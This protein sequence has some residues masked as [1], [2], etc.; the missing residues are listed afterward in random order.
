MTQTLSLFKKILQLWENQ[1]GRL[2]PANRSNF[3]SHKL[4]KEIAKYPYS[5]IERAM[6][7][8]GNKHL[9]DILAFLELDAEKRERNRIRYKKVY[10]IP[11]GS[12]RNTIRIRERS[13]IHVTEMNL[14]NINIHSKD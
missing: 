6:V 3:L 4:T 8:R 11:C 10:T 5:R 14:E 1:F 13:S 9:G 7:E 12:K 2:S